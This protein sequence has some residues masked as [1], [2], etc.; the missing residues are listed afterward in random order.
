MCSDL[1]TSVYINISDILEKKVKQLIRT[2]YH[3]ENLRI[4][5]TSKPLATPGGKNMVSNLNK[6]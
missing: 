2:V 6:A 4:I 3:A 1:K 5:F